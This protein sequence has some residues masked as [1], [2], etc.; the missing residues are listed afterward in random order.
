MAPRIV[1][2]V[3]P[4]ACGK[5]TLGVLLA[6]RYGGEVVSADSM[7]I[8][9]GMTIGTAAPTA[10]EMDGVPH[11]MIA[12]ADPAEQWSAARYAQAAIPIVDDIL[13]RGKL[14][15]LVGGTG[16]WLDAVVQ[17]REFAPG[18]AGGAVRRELEAQLAAEGMEPLLQELRR[19]DPESAARLHPA[20]TK[21]ILRAL[22]VYRETGETITAH[23]ERTRS[24]PPRYDA[25]WLGLRFADREDMKALIDRR[26]DAMVRSGLEEEVRALLQSG[27]PPSATA[28][29]AIGYKEFLGVLEG[30]ATMEQ[31]VAEVKLRSR[32]YAKRQLTW[33]RRNPAIHWMEW[34][35]E[36][37][38]EQALQ[39]ST[40][41]LTAAGVC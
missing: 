21:R 40:E 25:V 30:T 33:L 3:G 11:H 18:Q 17:G 38:F 29:Q 12:V 36:R 41:I 1:C 16:L 6:K 31:A 14:P 4:T 32:Q 5:T 35:K 8:Y 13:K 7:Q 22:E 10:E 2:V 37:N 23:D 26:V 28:W 34:E 24:L 20:D 15:I 9:R 27:L 19:V 39:L